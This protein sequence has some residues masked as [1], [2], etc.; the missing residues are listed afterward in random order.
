MPLLHTDSCCDVAIVA[1]IRPVEIPDRADRGPR[2]GS[3]PRSV[4]GMG[5]LPGRASRRSRSGGIWGGIAKIT[6]P[7]FVVLQNANFW[8]KMNV[9]EACIS[10]NVSAKSFEIIEDSCSLWKS[11][12]HHAAVRCQHDRYKIAKIGFGQ[13]PILLQILERNAKFRFSNEA[14]MPRGSQYVRHAE[15]CVSLGDSC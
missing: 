9:D 8:S 12:R 5:R 13:S 6:K 1:Q 10:L 4:A 7:L 3:D 11:M 14:S 2:W 15:L